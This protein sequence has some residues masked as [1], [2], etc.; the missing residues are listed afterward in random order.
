MSTADQRFPVPR[1]YRTFGR[2]SL[3]CRAH[4]WGFNNRNV[5][6][7]VPR[8]SGPGTRVEHRVAGAD[9]NPYLVLAAIVPETLPPTSI[10]AVMDGL[11]R[12]AAPPP[13]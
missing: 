7:R 5:A 13:A 1:H 12:A 10:A 4:S 6:L 11:S 2:S 9:A 8:S 3:S